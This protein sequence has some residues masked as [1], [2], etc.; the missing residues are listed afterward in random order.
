MIDFDAVVLAGGSSRRMGVRQKTSMLVGDQRL[1]DRAIGAVRDADRIVV[2]GPRC[3][4]ARAVR[5]T[6]EDPPGGGPVAALAAGLSELDPELPGKPIVV[7]AG[8]V[9]FAHPA[10]SR[11][12]AELGEHEVALLVDAGGNDQYLIAVWQ[13]AALRTRLLSQGSAAG[14]PMR[15]LFAGA[16][17][18]RS[19]AQGRES[20]DCDE[21]TDVAL[22]RR[23]AA[24]PASVHDTTDS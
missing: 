14:A 17:A 2:V 18:I 8:D 3:A 6:R 7:L 11:L 4:T 1:L 9:P 15:E 19:V 5:W 13:G 22:A 21:P 20:L 23:I 10:V 12:L 24:N 16:D